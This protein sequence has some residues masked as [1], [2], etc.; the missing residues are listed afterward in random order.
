MRFALSGMT[1]VVSFPSFHTAMAL[2]YCWAFRKTGIV[3]GAI[4]ALNIVMLCAVPFF[5]GHYLVDMIAGAAA[6]LIALA[7]LKT[8]QQLKKPI[9]ASASPGSAAASGGAY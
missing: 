8:A 1:G 2:A 9:A 3:G 4:I 6:M 7:V 5:G